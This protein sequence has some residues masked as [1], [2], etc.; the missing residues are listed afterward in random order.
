[1]PGIEGAQLDGDRLWAAY[2]RRDARDDLGRLQHP[3]LRVLSFPEYMP[4]SRRRG[5]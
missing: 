1:V 3:S 2:S 4:Y 5:R